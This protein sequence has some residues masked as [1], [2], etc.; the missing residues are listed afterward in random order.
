MVTFLLLE[1][2]YLS[3]CLTGYYGENCLRKCVETCA[4]C[5]N[6]NGLCDSD[7]HSGWKGN[8]C[9]QRK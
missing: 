7:C 9:Q 8:Y 2:H 6:V 4:N 1:K 5:D 3:A